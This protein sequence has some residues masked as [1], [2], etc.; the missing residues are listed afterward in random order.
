MPP[1][2]FPGEIVKDKSE[3]SEIADDALAVSGRSGGGR[4]PFGAMKRFQLFW[5]DSSCPKQPSVS[6]VISA[7]LQ[8]TVRKRGQK[9]AITPN[10]GRRWRPRHFGLPRHTIRRANFDRR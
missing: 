9:N 10:A 6:H 1:K 8:F 3:R 7:S 4:T 5:F 2:F